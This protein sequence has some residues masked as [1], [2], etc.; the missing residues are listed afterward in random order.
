MENGPD[1]AGPVR[2]AAKENIPSRS[3]STTPVSAVAERPPGAAPVTTTKRIPE[4]DGLRGV[5]ALA[6]VV[7]HYLGEV[8]HGFAA[9]MIGWYGVDLFFVLSGFLM[10]SIILN[11]HTEP[12]F[13]T[14]FYRRRAARIIPIYFVVVCATIGLAALTQGNSLVGSAV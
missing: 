12:R 13:L 9:L 3:T 8:P 10:G 6:V 14:S 4:L 5:A 2:L 11:H 1:G 7:A